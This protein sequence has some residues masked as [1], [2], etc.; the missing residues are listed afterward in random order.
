MPIW[1]LLACSGCPLGSTSSRTTMLRLLKHREVGL[2]AECSNWQSCGCAASKLKAFVTHQQ[3]FLS[4]G[5]VI[6]INWEDCGSDSRDCRLT[7]MLRITLIPSKHAPARVH[8]WIH[9]YGGPPTPALK[10]III[11]ISLRP[12]ACATCQWCSSDP[13]AFLHAL[14]FLLQLEPMFLLQEIRINIPPTRSGQFLRPLRAHLSL[15]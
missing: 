3:S 14:P 13:I 4:V 2:A 11:K 9:A 6:R 12:L 10:P 5:R 15:S 7:L 8:D 1:A